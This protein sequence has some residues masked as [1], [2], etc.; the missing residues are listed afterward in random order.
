MF[1]FGRLA[2]AL[3]AGACL[4]VSAHAAEPAT[5]T[6]GTIERLDP[7]RFPHGR[8]ANGRAITPLYTV[9]VDVSVIPLGTALF[10]LRPKAEAAKAANS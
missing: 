2:V 5:K 9:A 10:V 7:A 1:C 8:G 3:A 6:L 4:I